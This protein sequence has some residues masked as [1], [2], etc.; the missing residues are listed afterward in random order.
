[1]RRLLIVTAALSATACSG[2][3]LN[4][5]GSGEYNLGDGHTLVI[6]G[7][8]GGGKCD[9]WGPADWPDMSADDLPGFCVTV[10]EVTGSPQHWVLW[11]GENGG[12]ADVYSDTNVSINYGGSEAGDSSNIKL[13]DV[14]SGGWKTIDLLIGDE[15]EPDEAQVFSIDVKA[16]RYKP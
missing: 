16:K 15:D 12:M 7:Q 2:P 4:P 14:D 11:W 3:G 1:M 10:A 6:E 8:A 9:W 13:S 5:N